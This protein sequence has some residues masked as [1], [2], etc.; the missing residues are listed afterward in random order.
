MASCDD[1]AARPLFK[2]CD[3]V[4]TPSGAFATIVAIYH[5]A[6]AEA[7]VEYPN[8]DVVRFQLSVLK[9]LPGKK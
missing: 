8:G 7:D 1:S 2:L 4:R 6:R 5:L 9:P 3:Q